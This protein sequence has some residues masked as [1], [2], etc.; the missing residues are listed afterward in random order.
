MRPGIAFTTGTNGVPFNEKRLRKS[1]TGIK[2][3]FE[4][5]EHDSVWN[6]PTGKTGLPFQNFRSSRKFSTETTRKAVF[7]YSLTRFFWELFVNGK[8]PLPVVTYNVQRTKITKNLM[9]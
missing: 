2:D 6:N 8:K 1:E 9:I 3:G 5:I 7:I 4:E